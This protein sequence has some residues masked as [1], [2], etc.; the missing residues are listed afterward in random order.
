MNS[1]IYPCIWF[2]GQ[3][4]SAAE[5]YCSVFNNASITSE[6]PM[7][8]EFVVSGQRILCINGGPNFI[9]NPSVS[10]F[11][12]CETEQEVD[13]L[14]DK[15]M[16]TGIARMPLARY[17]WSEKY[18]W[19]QDR[20]H[21]N[22]QLSLGK[23]EDVG[24]KISPSLLFTG[25][26]NGKAEEAVQFY[27]SVFENSSVRGILRYTAGQ[28]ETEGNVAHAQFNLGKSVFMAMDSSLPHQFSFNEA[29]SFIVECFTQNEIDYYW[30][31]LSAYPEAEQCGWLK[32]K[33]GISWQIIPSILPKLM[34]DPERSENVVHAFM[35]MKKF[36]IEKLL[37]AARP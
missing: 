33:F 15:L 23:M 9:P 17:D 16:E 8:T 34:N 5:Y 26:L 14:W 25:E 27:T 1:E 24:Q 19:L 37:K 10:F 11:V 6:S 29:I 18:G 12:V 4:Q 21:I 7:A 31:K 3:A 20:Y 13:L 2:D 35:Q 30:E 32:D 22:W 36:D 28:D